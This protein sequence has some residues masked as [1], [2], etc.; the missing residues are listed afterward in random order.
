MVMNLQMQSPGAENVKLHYAIIPPEVP[1][2]HDPGSSR[3]TIKLPCFH[4]YI[5][6][7]ELEMF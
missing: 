7:V 2:E 1:G 4:L 6:W 5:L 3:L